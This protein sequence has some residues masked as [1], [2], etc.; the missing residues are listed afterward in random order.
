M[1][2]PASRSAAKRSATWRCRSRSTCTA[3]TPPRSPRRRRCSRSRAISSCRSGR[4]TNSSDASPVRA[5]WSRSRRAIGHDAFLK[6]V[7]AVDELLTHG[8]RAEGAPCRVSPRHGDARGARGHRRPM[9]QHGAVVPPIHLSSTYRFPAFG[10]KG[11]YDYSRSGN[12]TRDQLAEAHR[13]AR[14]GRRGRRHRLGHGRGDARACSWCSPDELIVATHDCYGGTHRLLTHLARRGHFDVAFDGPQRSGRGGARRSHGDRA[15]SGSRRRAIHCCASPTSA[16]SR[17]RPTR[18]A[19]WWWPTTPS[20]RR[21]C[22][23]RSPSAPTSWCTP[24]RSTSTVTVTSSAA[25]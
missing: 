16:P 1:A 17:M 21:H 15:W 25:R 23:S 7:E 6:E 14:G 5:A 9:A 24:P 12:P 2:G 19:P 8:P 22:S 3:S 11:R 10:V 13:G 4:C 18:P 20:S